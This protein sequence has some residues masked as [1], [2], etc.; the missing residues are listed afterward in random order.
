MKL[1]KEGNVTVNQ[2]CEI[3]KCLVHQYRREQLMGYTKNQ[4]NIVE[5]KFQIEVELYA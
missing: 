2:I 1:Y 4:K 5:N 3:T